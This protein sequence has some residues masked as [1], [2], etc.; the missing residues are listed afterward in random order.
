MYEHEKQ[1]F[2][3]LYA[4]FKVKTNNSSHLQF[5]FYAIL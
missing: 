4:K 2:A 1:L 3:C 5:S